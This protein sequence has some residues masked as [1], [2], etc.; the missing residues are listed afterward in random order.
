MTSTMIMLGSTR[1]VPL[2]LPHAPNTIP[3]PRLVAVAV[4]S[5]LPLLSVSCFYTTLPR[6][7]VT[8]LQTV[9]TVQTIQTHIPVK[10]TLDD[11][12]RKE[13]IKTK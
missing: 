6:Y 12:K 8:M 7:T 5:M 13:R 1:I 2:P 10:I 9:Q 11:T 3:P 4:V